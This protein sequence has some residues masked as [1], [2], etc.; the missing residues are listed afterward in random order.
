MARGVSRRHPLL[1]LTW[2]IAAPQLRRQLVPTGGSVTI[3]KVAG[4]SI[5]G[6]E[7]PRGA[8][9]WKPDLRVS[10]PNYDRVV[11]GDAPAG[12]DLDEHFWK[13]P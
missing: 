3:G 5:T 4:G 7:R 11:L 1:L 2:Q 13:M 9:P 12:R 8:S 6:S 10:G